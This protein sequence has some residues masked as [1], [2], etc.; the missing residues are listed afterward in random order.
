LEQ[1][2]E[3]TGWILDIVMEENYFCLKKLTED[4]QEDGRAFIQLRSIEKI[5]C[6]S[7]V[8]RCIEMLIGGV[9]RKL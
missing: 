2:D 5:I 7:G 1:G 8:E 3:L 9:Q 6:N 4:G